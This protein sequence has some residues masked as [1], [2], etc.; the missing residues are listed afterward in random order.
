ML[1]VGAEKIEAFKSIIESSECNGKKGL[2][3]KSSKVFYVC[4]L[5]AIS[6]G[7]RLNVSAL[8]E[9]MGLDNAIGYMNMLN[10]HVKKEDNFRYQLFPANIEVLN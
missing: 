8:I 9:S 1:E 6:N 7:I 5:K 3:G 4:F 2:P 10:I